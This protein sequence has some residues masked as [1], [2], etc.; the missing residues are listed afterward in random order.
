LRRTIKKKGKQ[1]VVVSFQ[2]QEYD[3]S[4]YLPRNAIEL[5]EAIKF[6][7]DFVPYQKIEL[8]A[9]KG[10]IVRNVQA[11]QILKDV[12]WVINRTKADTKDRLSKSAQVTNKK[13]R[14]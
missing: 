13:K 4:I 1:T 3:A 5:S 6:H 7:R 11:K 2:Q 9:I 14:S 10:R 12:M 8:C